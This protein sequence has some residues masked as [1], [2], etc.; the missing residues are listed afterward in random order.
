[1]DKF[2]E[3][4][5]VI[6]TVLFGKYQLCRILGTGRSGTVYLAV[7][8]G[9]EEYR[10]IKQVSKSHLD[11]ERFRREALILKD[12][13]HPGI[14]II[15]DVEEDENF[16]YLIEE[17]LEGDSLYDLVLHQGHLSRE[18]TIVYGIQL[19]R[20]IHYLH[21]A[22]P[23]PILHLDLQ[24]K[25]L[26]L[27]HETI[28]LIDFDHAAPAYEANASSKRYGTLEFAAP[29]QHHNN[30]ELDQ[31][32]DLYA[33]GGILHFLY[34]GAFPVMPYEGDPSMDPELAAV[35]GRC[36]QEE[37]VMRF[38]SAQ[39]LE[40]GLKQ[41]ARV[42]T[43]ADHRLQLSPLT[44]ALTGSGSGAGTTHV[45][46]GLSTY[47]R[48][49]GYPNL[50]EEMNDSGMGNGLGLY[51][52][53]VRDSFGIMQYRGFAWKPAYGAEVKL[54][55]PPYETRILDFGHQPKTVSAFAD[56]VILVCDSRCWNQEAVEKS[57]SA[58]LRLSMPYMVVYNHTDGKSRIKMP[59]G[60]D[61]R[62]CLKVP[63]FSDPFVIN[64]ETKTF[65]NALVSGLLGETQSLCGKR[66]ER[67]GALKMMWRKLHKKKGTG[68][69]GEQ[70]AK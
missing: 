67:Q 15:Y 44:I 8:L 12:L 18:L 70:K 57:V 4:A 69:S 10:A 56:V 20:I 43:A 62:R 34:T 39:E 11:Y 47:L 22:G 59:E 60:V 37:K 42:G 6:S 23:N 14:P 1:M 5:K 53:A 27:C 25:N 48:N 61:L 17:Y 26:L 32:T 64:R 66:Q 35:I 9:L 54:A 55:P 49:S 46:V 28:K 52:G 45:A 68:K 3:V 33:I 65:Y 51:S 21:V 7:H 13:R 50:Y 29:E 24:P 63:W 41:L 30:R 40:E 2:K 16:S 19:A 36:L 38:S 58:L 31:R